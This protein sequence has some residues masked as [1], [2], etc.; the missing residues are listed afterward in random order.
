MKK[1]A[2]YPFH[3]TCS[4]EAAVSLQYTSEL[5][6]SLPFFSKEELNTSFHKQSKALSSNHAAAGQH[7]RLLWFS[8]PMEPMHELCT[9]KESHQVAQHLNSSYLAFI[10]WKCTKMNS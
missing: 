5:Q 9:K 1:N 8:K 4:P 10:H 2:S 6:Q 7:K 3:Q